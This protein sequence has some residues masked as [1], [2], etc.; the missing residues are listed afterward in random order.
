MA[1][2]HDPRDAALAAG[3]LRRH[4]GADVELALVLLAAVGMR[5]VDHHL[6]AQARRAQHGA[7]RLD[8]GGRVVG[9]L[10]AAQDQVAVLVAAGLEDRRQ[11]HLG[12]SH[13]GMLG[14]RRDDRV[15][16]HLDAAV[17]AVLEADRAAQAAGELAVALAL[18]GARADRAPAD[19]VADELRRQQVEELGAD[20]QPDFQHIE[21]QG[22]GAFQPLVDREAAVQ[23]RVVDVALPAHRGA[24]LLEIDP[25]HDQ[26]V[27]AQRVGLCF[28]PARIVERLLV[29]VDRAGSDDDQQAVV[30]AVQHARDLG[31]A[32]LDQRLCRFRC[33][34]P[35]LQQ[36]GGQQR[37]HGADAQVVGSGL[38][39]GMG[40]RGNMHRESFSIGGG[41]VAQQEARQRRLAALLQRLQEL[42]AR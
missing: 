23:V 30:L 20:R 33:R 4:V 8:I 11:P 13:E 22:A 28:Q 12:H 27:L 32:G 6:L 3:E 31:A 21:Q 14:L 7:G 36:R 26:Q 19:Q 39:L 40:M 24:R 10:A 29:I 5:E 38:V 17:G 41:G 25:H 16:R 35:F 18:G 9:L 37:A 1:L 15:G 42:M 2:D 34:Q